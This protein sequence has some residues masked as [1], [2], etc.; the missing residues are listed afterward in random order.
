[1]HF[2]DLVSEW[3]CAFSV[4][5]LYI[6]YLGSVFYRNISTSILHTPIPVYIVIIFLELCHYET[7]QLKLSDCPIGG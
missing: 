5:Q 7:H 6:I 4:R 3:G 1:M 2:G